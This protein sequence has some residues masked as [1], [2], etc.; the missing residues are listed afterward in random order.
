[1]LENQIQ[2]EENHQWN[3]LVLE[4]YEEQQMPIHKTS[5]EDWMV[6]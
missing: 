2:G 6:L 3:I 4:I 1:M 5:F